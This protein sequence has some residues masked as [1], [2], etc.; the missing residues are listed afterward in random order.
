M[1]TRF[2]ASLRTDSCPQPMEATHGLTL[3]DIRFNTTFGLLGS[4]FGPE[5]TINWLCPY[6]LITATKRVTTIVASERTPF[7]LLAR[8]TARRAS[9]SASPRLASAARFSSSPTYGDQKGANREIR[10]WH[11]VI[12]NGYL[13]M[14][15]SKNPRRKVR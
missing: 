6:P 15:K 13:M 11:F 4:W 5:V 7:A 9:S 12:E 8:P 2:A 3:S 1:V 10:V 14:D